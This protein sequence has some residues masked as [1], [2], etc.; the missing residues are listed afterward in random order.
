[1]T[2]P[3][4]PLLP[5]PPWC[6]G[7]HGGQPAW[8]G[9]VF[10]ESRPVILD[11]LTGPVKVQ[12]VTALTQYPKADAPAG[13]HVHAWSHMMATVTMSQPSDVTA[14]ADMLTGYAAR[15]RAVADELVIAQ[16]QDRARVEADLKNAGREE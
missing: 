11:A 9:V 6:I 2:A 14:F 4:D 15:L 7:S 8:R 10:H 13:R 3:D 12:F 1:M 5:C 16:Q